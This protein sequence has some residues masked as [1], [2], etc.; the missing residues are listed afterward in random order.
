MHRILLTF[1]FALMS[2]MTFAQTDSTE[3]VQPQV[4]RLRFGYLSCDSALHSLPEYAT[5]IKSLSDLKA[6]YNAEMKRVEDEFNQKYELFLD[7][8]R[9]LA[10][11]IREKRQ[12]ELQELMEKNAAFKA[13]AKSLISNAEKEALAPLKKKID[14]AIRLVG[15]RRG[16]MFII[17]TDGNSL[18]YADGVM[19]EDITDAVI[20]LS[21]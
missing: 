19:G 3:V 14:N 10:P 18:P 1:I 2:V 7:T 12:A 15:K 16:L 17:N 8:Q 4:P 9:D 6:S 11:T 20:R 5:T 21:K 13:K